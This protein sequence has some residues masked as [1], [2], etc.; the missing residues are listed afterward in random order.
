MMFISYLALSEQLVPAVGGS[1]V[2]TGSLSSWVRVYVMVDL[3]VM[4]LF[5]IFFVDYFLVLL[6]RS[7][8]LF[9]DGDTG[10]EDFDYC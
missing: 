8:G 3:F 5:V 1:A 4:N 9:G 6:S 10:V 7:S 2:D